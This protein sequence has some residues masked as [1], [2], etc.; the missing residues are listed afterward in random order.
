MINMSATDKIKLSNTIVTVGKF[1]GLHKGHEK[2]LS[3]LAKKANGR[4]KVVLTF[5]AEPKD[6]LNNQ[7]VKTIVTDE[8]KRLLC[9]KQGIYVYCS[10]PMTKEFLA[11]EP[12]EFIK[13]FLKKKIRG[14]SDCVRTGFL[15]W[16]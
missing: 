2:L 11:L 14:Y 3:E 16:K 8:E 1:D 5:A 6:V 4:R 12:D 15:F 13:E 9:E 7:T 10:M